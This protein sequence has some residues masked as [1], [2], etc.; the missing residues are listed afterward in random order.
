MIAAIAAMSISLIITMRLDHYAFETIGDSYKSN[1]ELNY[2]SHQLAETEKAMETYVKYHTFESIDTYYH[3]QDKVESYRVIMQSNPSTDTVLQKEYIVKQL[4]GTFIFYSGKAVAA[5]R[6][7]S[8]SDQNFY[9]S[10]TLECYN[11]L[12]TQISELNILFLEK[13]AAVYNTDRENISETT[14]ASIVF[15]VLF[16]IL[17]LLLLYILITSITK[18]LAKISEVA[19][20]L[21]ERDFDVPLFNKTTHDEIG[22]IC[23][24]FDRMIISIREY[25]DTIWE[26]AINETEL[27][28]KEIEMQALY[29]DAQLRAFQNQ[30][31]PH[32]L[33]NTL[34]TGAQLA[35]M[36]GADKTCYFIEQ[37]ADFFRYN[38]QQQK[39]TA[40]IDEELGLVD[41][42]V[43]IM[44]VRFGTRL[45]FVK[46][47]PSHPLHE[48]LPSMTLQPLVENC[49]K[50]GLRNAKGKVTLKI[51]DTPG[52]TVISI[53]DNGCGMPSEIR[54][55]VMAA[56]L[57]ANIQLPVQSNLVISD[58]ENK[59]KTDHTGTGLINVFSR[60]RLYFH[61]DDVF[62]ITPNDEGYG[63]KFIIRIP[64]NV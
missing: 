46:E 54:S 15:I 63:T 51:E 12:L 14:R 26:K 60:L 11:M 59:S 31:N 55:Q 9:Y 45:E 7:N 16:F 4:T 61:R 29:A 28:E 10:K 57:S 35:M 53:A 37:V 49:I 42:F 32:F 2:F 47:T 36:E 13:N 44:K 18:P 30:I 24:A 8:I 19:H 25:I 40:S 21:A 3:Y 6:A 62:D 48:M 22:N 38:I 39:L 34:N 1:A 41:N 33:F 58:T 56:A 27:K 5:R 52:F 64:E 43:Y 20:R 17:I 23:R 50:H